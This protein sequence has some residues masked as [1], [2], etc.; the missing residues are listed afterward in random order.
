MATTEM[1]SL[2]CMMC[3]HEYQEKV[4]K[5]EDVERSCPKCRSNSI[6]QLKRKPATK[7]G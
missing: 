7:A 6:R 3:G 2:R 1:A 4:V 5:G